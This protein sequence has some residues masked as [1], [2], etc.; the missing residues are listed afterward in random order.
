MEEGW[1]RQL[2]TKGR[3]G[4]CHHRPVEGSYES[5]GRA[6][7]VRTE[8]ARV[9]KGEVFNSLALGGHGKINRLSGL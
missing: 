9:A 7:E 8:D 6:V 5:P 2:E 4:D 1:G 3:L